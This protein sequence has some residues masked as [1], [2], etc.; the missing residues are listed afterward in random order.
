MNRSTLSKLM[1]VAGLVAAAALATGAARAADPAYAGSEKCKGC[2]EDEYKSWKQSYH[3]KMVRPKDE[4]ILKDVVENWAK[5]GP[6]KV[7]LTGAPAKLDDVVMVVG[8]KWKQ[9]FLVKNAAT[10]GML[11]LDKQWNTVHKRWEPYG[12]KNDWDTNCATCH[13]TGFRLTSYDPAKPAEQKWSM[14]EVNIGCEACHG[15]AAEHAKAKGK[16]PVYSFKGKSVE[17]QT[18]VCGY[19]HIRL[20]NEQFKT[21]QGNDSEYLPHPEVGKTWL[22]GDD[23]TKWYPDKAVI[24]GVHPEDRID[25]TYKGDLAGMFKLDEQSKKTGIYDAGKHHQQYQEYLQ[26]KHYKAANEKD[27]MSCSACHSS[28]AT[29]AKPKL[30][31]A[32][33]TCIGCHKKGEY[34]VEKHMP[35]TGQTAKDLFM[36][37]HTFNKDQARASGPTAKDEPVYFKK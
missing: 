7:N 35:G 25:A 9:R 28:H 31:K 4:A 16:K 24:P 21:A 8:S 29:E 22:P 36:R 1:R 11:F 20:D 15:P 32:A 23:W 34:T 12:Q 3:A 5:D 6:A 30:V 10:G 14:A 37:T 33:D 2:H 13:A 26:S 18:R 19:C 27:R 17:E